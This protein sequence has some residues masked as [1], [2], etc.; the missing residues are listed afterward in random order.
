M[1]RSNNLGFVPFVTFVP[2]V[3]GVVSEQRLDFR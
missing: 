3:F 2:F 1:S